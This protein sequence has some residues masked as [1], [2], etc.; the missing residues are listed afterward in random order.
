M[1]QNPDSRAPS[2]PGVALLQQRVS[3]P[4]LTDPGPSRAQ[5]ADLYKA[6]MRAPDHAWLRPWRFIEVSGDDR[7]RLGECMA[8]SARQDDP[9]LADKAYQKLLNSPLRAPLVLIAWAK[10]SQHPKVPEIEQV[11]ATGA[12]VANLVNAAYALGIGAVWRTGAPAYSPT[13]K[14][15]LGLAPTDHIVGFIYLG[16]PSGEDKPVPALDP[17]DFVS[18]LPT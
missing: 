8:H 9:D 11:L 4:R 3:H 6:A 5:L 2:H 14:E 13:L 1:T 10:I 12:A 7:T 18:S 16:T 17:A 15:S